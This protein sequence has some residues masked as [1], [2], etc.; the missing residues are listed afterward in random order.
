MTHYGFGGRLNASFPSQFII[1]VTEVCNLACIHCPH[2]DFK[3]SV[4]YGAKYLD[5]QLH[6]RLVDEVNIWGKGITGYLRYTS[7]GEPLIHPKIFEMMGYASKNTAGALVALT[8]NANMTEAAYIA[9]V[10]AAFGAD[11]ATEISAR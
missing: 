1:D 2:P 8:T 10:K 11:G 5:P 4:H 9:G 3:K 7:Q 6:D